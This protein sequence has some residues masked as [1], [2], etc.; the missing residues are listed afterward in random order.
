ME[1]LKFNDEFR[2]RTKQN[3][4][5]VIKLYRVLQ[6]K[7]DHRI[8]GR[9]LIRSVTSVA[10]NFRASCRARSIAE[11]YSKLCIVIEE[12]DE[13]L[14][15]LELIEESC[16]INKRIIEPLKSETLSIL[17]VLSKTRKSLKPK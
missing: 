16:L 15:W 2:Q 6:L 3:A 13:T 14:F 12:C 5:N 1:P 4:L 10:A 7:E 17:M 9:Q 8:M 11:R